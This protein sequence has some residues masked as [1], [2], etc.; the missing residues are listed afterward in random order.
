M[1]FNYEKMTEDFDNL[2]AEGTPPEAAMIAVV[3]DLLG[4]VRDEAANYCAQVG[5]DDADTQAVLDVVED[6]VPDFADQI[7]WLRAN[8]R[9]R[10]RG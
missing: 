8:L 6:R 7:D 1:A 3:T 4:L 2:K 5:S 9:D 10:I